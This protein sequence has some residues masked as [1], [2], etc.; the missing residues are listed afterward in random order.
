[1]RRSHPEMTALKGIVGAIGFALLFRRCQPLELVEIGSGIECCPPDD[2][3][4]GVNDL[5][6]SLG[7]AANG[8]LVFSDSFRGFCGEG[9]SGQVVRCHM[10]VAVKGFLCRL[11]VQ[12]Q[13]DRLA[14]RRLLG[15]VCGRQFRPAQVFIDH[16]Q[17]GV[18]VVVGYDDAVYVSKAKPLAGGEPVGKA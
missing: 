15:P 17:F 5:L 6:A 18:K 7:I 9:G 8:A 12:L 10:L 16:C 1:M 2:I 13:I 3:D 14:P 4:R 11:R